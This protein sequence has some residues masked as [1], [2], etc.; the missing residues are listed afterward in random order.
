MKD[1]FVGNIMQSWAVRSVGFE[2]L[3]KDV[4]VCGKLLCDLAVSYD[5]LNDDEIK[6]Y[7][8]DTIKL[9]NKAYVESGV[10]VDEVKV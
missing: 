2:Q 5:Y 8:N 3:R 10:K 6:D 7:I 4:E 1:K 9:L